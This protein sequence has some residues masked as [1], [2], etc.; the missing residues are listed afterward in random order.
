M[1][2]LAVIYA[3][4]SS[5]KQREESIEGQ[6]RECTAFADANDIKIIGTYIDRAMSARTDKRPDFL[7]MIADSAKGVLGSGV[8]RR[9]GSSPFT[10]TM[11]GRISSCWFCLFLLTPQNLVSLTPF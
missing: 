11:Q 7:R 9:K 4:F 10:R 8:V 6:I 1:S 3:R 2:K 5:D